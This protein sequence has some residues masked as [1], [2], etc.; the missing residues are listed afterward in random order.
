MDALGLNSADVLAI[1]VVLSLVTIA[2]LQLHAFDPCRVWLVNRADLSPGSARVLAR[3]ILAVL[4]LLGS[5]LLHLVIRR[6]LQATGLSLTDRLAGLLIGGLAT[7]V[8]VLMVFV[9]LR[10][11]PPDRRP[12]A[13][14]PSSWIV[15]EVIGVRTQMVDEIVTRVRQ[16]ETLIRDHAR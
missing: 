14:G 8:A 1:L 11:R 2:F 15:R 4:P 12:G 3:V 16:G 9:A 10:S 13:V 5:V 6:L 7:S